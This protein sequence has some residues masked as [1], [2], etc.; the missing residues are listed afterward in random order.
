MGIAW[1]KE[2][3]PL[4]FFASEKGRP[5]E[6][7]KKAN[8]YEENCLNAFAP[9]NSV[10]GSG[11]EQNASIHRVPN[12]KHATIIVKFGT[13]ELKSFWI[14]PKLIKIFK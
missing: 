1:W 5:G 9:L 2:Y 14:M 7:L 3:C 8:G 10:G 11:W 4:D 12:Q 6:P 13:F